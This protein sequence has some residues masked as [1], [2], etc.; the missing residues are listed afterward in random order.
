[1]RNKQLLITCL[2]FALVGI[3]MYL[4][5][6]DHVARLSDDDLVWMQ[7]YEEGD[8]IFFRNQTSGN[9]DTL[10][11][12][13]N[14]ANSS[15]L[16]F[17]PDFCNWNKDCLE[18]GFTEMTLKHGGISYS[19]NSL[20]I[21]KYDEDIPCAVSWDIMGLT[22]DDE[23]NDA[24][25]A[26]KNKSKDHVFVSLTD[27]EIKGIAFDDCLIVNLDLAIFIAIKLRNQRFFLTFYV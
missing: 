24:T 1:M 18:A 21:M 9:E 20:F 13:Y 25:Y 14:H 11:V 22:S 16:P 23:L 7:A 3:Y 19:R 12:N 27:A 15:R 8:S 17:S 6:Y 4:Q 5:W 2:P 26:V 10:I